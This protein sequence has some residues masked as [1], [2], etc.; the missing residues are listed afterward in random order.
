[1]LSL[2]SARSQ[3]LLGLL[4]VAG[5]RDRGLVVL[6]RLFHDPTLRLPSKRPETFPECDLK[7]FMVDCRSHPVA[8]R[9]SR[10]LGLMSTSL[11]E[12]S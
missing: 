6:H 9:L 2:A 11:L 12:N 1:M 10:P 8:V 4:A 7:D 3:A 5:R